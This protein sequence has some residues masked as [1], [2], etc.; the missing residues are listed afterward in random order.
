MF[1]GTFFPDMTSFYLYNLIV[2][3]KLALFHY[4]LKSHAINSGFR[5]GKKISLLN[6]FTERAAILSRRVAQ[7]SQLLFRWP[8]PAVLL[9]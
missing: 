2:S 9:K 4:L 6:F 5:G 3:Y 8:E 7:L 1:F